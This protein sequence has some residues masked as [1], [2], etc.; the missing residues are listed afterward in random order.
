MRLLE[1]KDLLNKNVEELELS[2]R[3]RNCFRNANIRY[4]G[5]LV[6]KTETDLLKIRNFGKKTLRG[7]K[8]KLEKFGLYLEMNVNNWSRPKAEK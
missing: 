2:V 8:E 4:F 5:E 7:V 3:A 1:E 6:Q